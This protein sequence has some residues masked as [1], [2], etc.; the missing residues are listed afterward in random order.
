M[1][2]TNPTASREKAEPA[3][4]P[5]Q[6]DA[7]NPV[8]SLLVKR[9]YDIVPDKPA[10][11]AAEDR[12]LTQIDEYY[13]MGDP[14]TSTVQYEADLAPFKPMTDVVF[15]GKALAAGGKPVTAMDAGMQVEGAGA[16]VVRVIGERQAFLRGGKLVFSE[17]KPFTEMELRYDNAYGGQ[18]KHAL[19]E[20]PFRYPRNDMGKGLLLKWRKGL[21]EGFELPNLEDPTDLLIPEGL[22]LQVPEAWPRAPMPQG[23]GWYPRT[24]YPRAFYAG[25]IPPYIETGTLTKEEFLGLIWKNH[26]VLARKRKLPGFHVRFLLGASQGLSFPYLRGDEA[27]RLR[28][29]TTEGMLRFLLPGEK[30]TLRLDIGEGTQVLDPVLHTVQIRG[31]ERQIDMVWRGCLPYPGIEYLADMTTLLAEVD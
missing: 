29:L 10:V 16:K 11:R 5:G 22:L 31:E 27:I 8:F 18:D 4:L 13:D 30:P 9:T 3:I 6:D 24:G 7:G 28:G 26:I 20:G 1:S 25:S 14:Q 17:P 21:E 2:A 15:V 23:L 19:P 12:P